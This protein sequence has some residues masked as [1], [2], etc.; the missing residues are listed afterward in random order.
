[1]A[2]SSRAV[3]EASAY[4]DIY[5]QSAD[6][7]RLYARD[8]ATHDSELAP[9]LCLPGLTRSSKDFETIAPVIAQKRRVIAVDFRGRGLSQHAPDPQTYRA[10]VELADTVALLDYL[11]INRVAVI[12]TSRGGIVAA[13]MAAQHKPRLAG[14]L[15]NDIGSRL[16][17]AGLLR[18]RNNLGVKNEF[19]SWGDAV[20]TLKRS[21]LG[22]EKLTADEWRSF[23]DRLFREI[24]GVPHVNYDSALAL[25]FP[26]VE[27]IE[28]G[29]PSDLRELFSHSR[30][31]P[32]AVLRG[33][34]SD[35][36]SAQTVEA[37]KQDNTA[38]QSTLVRERGHAPFLDEPESLD[39]I[40]RWLLSVDTCVL[41]ALPA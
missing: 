6:S 16:D 3:T 29:K 14:I 25:T 39:A 9:V 5:Y 38:L 33:E 41:R 23:A 18:I 27:N 4:T 1:M 30:D 37:M 17:P 24:D 36:L 7:L 15:F 19:K 22:F 11:K 34:H 40:N 26:T 21:N 2:R 31:F 32:V 35:L 28:S 13:L 8:Y 10:D 20:S 12:G